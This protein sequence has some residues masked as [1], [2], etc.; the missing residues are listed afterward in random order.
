MQIYGPFRISTTQTLG[1]KERLKA[2]TKVKPTKSS[3]LAAVDHDD[4]SPA[5]SRLEASTSIAGSGEIRFDR[6]A[7]LRHQISRGSYETPSK[8][9][10]AID[11]LIEHFA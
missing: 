9:E 1:G 2:A 4:P 11:R 3:R 8:L 7:E 10:A 5:A 6:V